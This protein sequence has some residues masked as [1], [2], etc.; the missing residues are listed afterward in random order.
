MV[1]ALIALCLLAALILRTSGEDRRVRTLVS[2]E[3]IGGFV[4]S[5]VQPDSDHTDAC[6]GTV[7]HVDDSF[8]LLPLSLQATIGCL[9]VGWLIREW[10]RSIATPLF[11]LA[12]ESEVA[13]VCWFL[14]QQRTNVSVL[15]VPE[16]SLPH[17]WGS[18][19]L[20]AVSKVTRETPVRTVTH[21][22]GLII[23]SAWVGEGDSP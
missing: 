1:P 18:L 2:A 7:V 17:W 13:D 8:A 14:A 19:E 22:D 10:K 6:S 11:V 20:L 23:F 15:T 5:Q 4:A 21:H 12:A 9:N 16:E 3:E